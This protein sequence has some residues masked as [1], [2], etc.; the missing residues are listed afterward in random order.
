M[1]ARLVAQARVRTRRL[2]RA[3]QISNCLE[4]IGPAQK[5][6]S[7]HITHYY[8]LQ[9]YKAEEHLYWIH[10]P[11]WIAEFASQRKINAVL[12]VGCAYGTLLAYTMQTAKCQGYAIDF[13]N[14][15]LSKGLIEHFGIH[16]QC[17][18]IELDPLPWAAKFEIILF[19]EVLEHLNFQCVPT[20]RKLREAL[21]PGGRLYLST[22]NR[23]DWGACNKYYRRYEE[24]P[25]PSSSASIVDDHVWHFSRSEL[26]Q[27]LATAGFRIRRTA[28]SP[29]I[30]ARHFN[31]E[32]E[33][34]G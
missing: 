11:G 10:L 33:S 29:G 18:N 26:L 4:S 13:K 24:L 23:A 3:S 28:E 20:L 17:A 5:L 22:P 6:V 32:A 9:S 34:A 30:A 31:V 16:F 1:I 14:P 15:Y 21:A 27:Q 7:E 8:Y 12:D 2:L 19:T 25:S